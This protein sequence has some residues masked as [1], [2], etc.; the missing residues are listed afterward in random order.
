MTQWGGVLEKTHTGQQDSLTGG[1]SRGDRKLQKGKLAQENRKA[2]SPPLIGIRTQSTCLL[3]HCHEQADWTWWAAFHFLIIRN[4]RKKYV[5][6]L[7][8]FDRVFAIIVSLAHPDNIDK[9]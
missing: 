3:G 4:T 1:D 7:G 8:Q 9:S 6:R 5:E 2:P